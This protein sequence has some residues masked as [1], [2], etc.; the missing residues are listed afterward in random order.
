VRKLPPVYHDAGPVDENGQAPVMH[1]RYIRELRREE[2]KRLRMTQENHERLALAEEK[3]A[4]RRQ[5]NLERR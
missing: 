5:R 1:K 2:R 3:R 4:R